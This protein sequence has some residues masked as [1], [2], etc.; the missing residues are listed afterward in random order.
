MWDG[1][2]LLLATVDDR[3]T[4]RVL[5]SEASGTV[6]SYDVPTFSI[7][8]RNDPGNWLPRIASTP[9][10]FA[11]NPR[12]RNP[13]VIEFRVA[14][15]SR[16]T[17]DTPACRRVAI[18]GRGTRG[19]HRRSSGLGRVPGRAGLPTVRDR[20]SGA[21][22]GGVRGDRAD[23][24]RSDEQRDL[25]RAHGLPGRTTVRAGGSLGCRGD[26]RRARAARSAAVPQPPDRL[27]PRPGHR[28]GSRRGCRRR[29]GQEP[30]PIAPKREPALSPGVR[31]LV[32]L[33]SSTRSPV[34]ASEARRRA[35][36]RRPRSRPVQPDRAASRRPANPR[37]MP[38]P[39]RSMS[40]A[41][42]RSPVMPM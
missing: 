20:T 38:W 11:G 15:H 39:S 5:A 23:R 19:D 2:R 10:R 17:S 33:A 24:P 30:T 41:V 6:Y 4:N 42:S 28:R 37:L 3:N 26:R 25:V 31:A 22:T 36:F 21:R 40:G 34:A 32:T 13:V 18:R 1:T 9:T 35:T 27:A 12:G 29:R 16:A 14:P 8:Q 7:T